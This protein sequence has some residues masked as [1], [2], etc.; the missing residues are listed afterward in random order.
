MVLLMSYIISWDRSCFQIIKQNQESLKRNAIFFAEDRARKKYNTEYPTLQQIYECIGLPYLNT[1]VSML[2]KKEEEL[3]SFLLCGIDSIR[4]KITKYREKNYKIIFISDMYLSSTFL[5][6]ILKREGLMKNDD[7]LF[8]SCECNASK[9]RG[10]LYKY[11]QLSISSKHWTHYGDNK[12]SDIKMALR[13]GLFPVKIEHHYNRFEKIWIDSENRISSRVIAAGLSKALRLNKNYQTSEVLAVDVIAFLYIPFVIWTLKQSRLHGITKLLFFARDSYLFYL[14]AKIL[15]K[16]LQTGISL[17]YFYISRKSL[18]LPSLYDCS[19]LD[20]KDCDES[21]LDLSWEEFKNKFS[22]PDYSPE[23][24]T[25]EEAICNMEFIKDIRKLS[26][27]ARSVFLEY[28]K[29]SGVTCSDRV[30]IVD[31]GW[32]GSGRKVI[33]KIFNKENFYPPLTLYYGVDKE[34][35]MSDVGDYL[36]YHYMEDNSHSSFLPSAMIYEHYF[37]ITSDNTTIGYQKELGK[38]LPIFADNEVKSWQKSLF[39][40]NC[41]G[42]EEFTRNLIDLVKIEELEMLGDLGKKSWMELKRKPNY[43]DYLVLKDI[44]VDHFGQTKQMVPSMSIIRFLFLKATKQAR[45]F[46]PEMSL[47]GNRILGPFN[48]FC[49]RLLKGIF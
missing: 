36:S 28:L 26:F 2:C 10:T 14:I 24:K 16:K 33:S 49:Y 1:D 6:E 7:Y 41:K 19:I 5:K 13:N 43:C 29:Q 20:F 17:I 31:L 25:P 39:K 32:I 37:S 45:L 8:V 4:N 38:V 30:G 40:I 11:V 23:Y 9:Y 48:L 27:A 46:W 47:V 21:C 42:I 3:E 12:Y 18:Y 35:K 15:E 34:R 22:I 44:E